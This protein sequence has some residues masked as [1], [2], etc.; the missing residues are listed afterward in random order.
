MS[1]TVWIAQLTL[2]RIQLCVCVIAACLAA[3]LAAQQSDDVDKLVRD[4]K[5]DVLSARYGDTVDE[6]QLAQ[7]ARAQANQ[8]RRLADVV[9]RRSS[10]LQAE[11][12]YRSWIN[13]ILARSAKYAEVRDVDAAA[14]RAE[15]AAMIL[16]G[17]AAR[18]LDEFEISDGKRLDPQLRDLLNSAGA[19]C[20]LARQAI[21]PLIAK[22]KTADERVADRFLSLGLY[23]SLRRTEPLVRYNLAWCNLHLAAIMP[24]ANA[25]RPAA[26]RAARLGFQRVIALGPEASVLRLCELGVAIVSRRQGRYD[27]ASARFRKLAG[28]RGDARRA[29]RT[30]YEWARNEI[31]A[32][33]FAEARKVLRPALALDPDQAEE[34]RFYVNLAALWDANSYLAEGRMLE[35]NRGEGASAVV[36]RKRSERVREIGLEKL[37]GLASRGGAWPDL[38]QLFVEPALRRDRPPAK[39]LPAELLFNARML[40][41]EGRP[42]AAIPLLSEA[43]RRGSLPDGLAGDVLYESAV[44]HYRVGQTRQAADAFEQLARRYPRHREAPRAIDS[45]C[46]LRI[47]LAQ[48]SKEP[49]AY[50]SAARAALY[51][52]QSFPNH[53]STDAARWWIPVALQAAGRYEE[54][55]RYFSRV[56]Q[57]SPHRAEARYRRVLC[58]R[59]AFERVRATL[60]ANELKSHA[61][62]VTEALR[63]YAKTARQRAAGHAA[64]KRLAGWSA[65]A[66]LSAAQV[67]VLD[68]VEDYQ[69]ALDMLGEFEKQY[70]NS[71]LLGRVLVVRIEAFRGLEQFERIKPAVARYL[72]AAT[73]G[74][75]AAGLARVAEGLAADALR[76]EA[77]GELRRTSLLAGVAGSLLERLDQR[78]AHAAGASAQRRAVRFKLAQMNYLG[79]RYPQALELV[80][81]LLRGDERDGALRRLRARVLTAA[82]ADNSAAA[83]IAEARDAWAALLSDPRLRDRE[84]QRYWEAR[85]HSLALLLRG[86]DADSVLRAIRQERVWRPKLGGERWSGM[87]KELEQQAVARAADGKP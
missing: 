86:G 39:Q 60:D 38:V 37:A 5:V 85:Y 74:R 3:P 8:A 42:A 24:D 68:G 47:Q 30:A 23:D 51:M 87:F 59:L 1:R 45:A 63:A 6:T 48:Q 10:F 34:A 22:M 73:S 71:A 26:L 15:L 79:G 58:E 80:E 35:R 40:M 19:Q 75:D 11:R 18:M 28:A 61:A 53:P 72:D 4:G 29:A 9:E 36:V 33:R 2:V 44:G 57:T 25:S 81:Q 62:H 13:A 52:L 50:E 77:A 56:P 27:D 67:S 84:P 65:A 70:A 64:D 43:R 17:S 55:A 82:L 16:S 12:R 21:E 46:R 41:G 49:A 14:A 66:L 31:D 78:L 54:A 83:A 32:G 20:E 7:L 76:L 69:A